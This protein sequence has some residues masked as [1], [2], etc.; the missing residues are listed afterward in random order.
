MARDN[1]SQATNDLPLARLGSCR[2]VARLGQGGMGDVYKAHDESLDRWVAIKVLPPQLARDADFVGR[3][4]AEASAIARL[5]HPNVVQVYSIGEEQGHHYFVMQ[6]VEGESLAERLHRVGRLDVVQALAIVQQ[7]LAG[8]VAAH[9]AGIVHRDIKPGN[10][11]LETRS[12][13]ALLADFG[14]AKRN[15]GRSAMT[16]TG[17]ILGTVDYLSPEQARGLAVDARSDLYSIGV[18]LYELLSGKLPF[19]A[20][21]ATAMIFQHAYEPPRPLADAA[22]KLSCDLTQIVDR[23]LRKSADER[24]QTAR[25]LLVDLEAIREGRT[26]GQSPPMS[27]QRAS[28]VLKAPEFGAEI[29]LPMAVP[30]SP[31]RWQRLRDRARSVVQRHTPEFVQE[32]QSTSQQVDAAVAEYARR[33]Q[34]LVC[35][36][37]EAQAVAADLA[38]QLRE[39][40]AAASEAHARSASA[41]A[42]AECA[43]VESQ[44]ADCDAQA[45]VLERLCDEQQRELH[46]IELKLARADATLARLQSQR[47]LLQAR[48]K[49]A[50]AEKRVAGVRVAQRRGRRLAELV[51]AALV[52][53]L[54]MAVWFKS[55]RV[56]TSVVDAPKSDLGSQPGVALPSSGGFNGPRGVMSNNVQSL[57]FA[58]DF[59]MKNY[60]FFIGQDDG[61]VREYT[62]FGARNTVEEIAPLGDHAKAIT[63]IVASPDLSRIAVACEDSTIGVWDLAT[64]REIRRLPLHSNPRGALQFSAD[65]SQLITAGVDGV[66][67]TWNIQTETELTGAI[68]SDPAIDIQAVAWSRDGSR[69]AIGYRLQGGDSLAL[70]D[71]TGQ[72]RLQLFRPSSKS[73]DYIAFIDK[74]QRILSLTGQEICVWDCET[75]AKV[76]TFG[77]ASAAFVAPDG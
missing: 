77:T 75:G 55:P 10:V 15:D 4:R 12:G 44:K 17:V 29:S 33:R 28:Q 76:D 66:L 60:R 14:L 26:V 27:R 7:C 54:L 45:A 47:D 51:T 72:R 71:V 58:S 11:L 30:E 69:A 62:L 53:L 57:A 16:A 46:D 41:T 43:A 21:S 70:W 1:P 20:E 74:D 67:R 8:L 2:V 73:T 39:Q 19:A 6:F 5:T 59:Q 38:E 35:L 48:L 18:M 63:A 36:R 68:T 49:A 52:L 13:R 22:P 31:N 61:A 40:R 34:K 50:G 3:F 25:E 9:E 32:L 42:R 24:Y 37:D 64:R 56:E 65:G 23:L